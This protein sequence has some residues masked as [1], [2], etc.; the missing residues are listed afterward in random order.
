M[1]ERRWKSR[2]DLEDVQEKER[3]KSMRSESSRRKRGDESLMHREHRRYRG[4]YEDGEGGRSRDRV[5]LFDF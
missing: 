4:R 3:G 5:G 1:R 2:R